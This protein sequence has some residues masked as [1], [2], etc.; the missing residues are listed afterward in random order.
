MRHLTRSLIIIFLNTMNAKIILV[1][2]ART[3]S[4]KIAFEECTWDTMN[5]GIVLVAED[6]SDASL[7][8]G[9]RQEITSREF[10]HS[11]YFC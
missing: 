8:F 2:L 11:L 9:A 5:H 3:L 6:A 7:L 10:Y 1:F 4:C